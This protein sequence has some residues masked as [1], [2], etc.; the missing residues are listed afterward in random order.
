VKRSERGLIRSKP[1]PK[2]SQDGGVVGGLVGGLP[3]VSVPALD[4]LNKQIQIFIIS[5][6]FEGY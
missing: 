5:V 4:C 3:D 6:I 1:G 2:E